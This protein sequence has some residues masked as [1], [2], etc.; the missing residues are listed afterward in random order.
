MVVRRKIMYLFRKKI[1]VGMLCLFF[2]LTTSFYPACAVEEK[3]CVKALVD[4]LGTASDEPL[5]PCRSISL[6]G[7][8]RVL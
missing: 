7:R 5:E 8:I 6:L 1:A 4:C 2:M 3:S